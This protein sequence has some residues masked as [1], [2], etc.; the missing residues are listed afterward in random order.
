MAL[1]H[2]MYQLAVEEGDSA[3]WWDSEDAQELLHDLTDD[4]NHHAPVN[5][6]F[7]THPGDGSDFGFWEYP[8][9]EK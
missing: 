7:G 1:P 5:F 3:A 8:E 2:G 6:Y 9:E 4:L